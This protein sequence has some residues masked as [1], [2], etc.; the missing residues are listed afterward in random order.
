M[1][2]AIDTMTSTD[3]ASHVHNDDAN[4][5]STRERML[6][7]AEELFAAHGY[8]GT[9]LRAIMARAN[10]NTGSVHYHFRTKENLLEALF[11]MRVE[12]MNAE[13]RALLAACE[14]QDGKDIPDLHAVLRAFLGPAIRFARS[15]A[16]TNFNKVSALCSVDPNE[17][18]RRIAFAAYDEVAR[19]FTGLLR[20]ACPWLDDH[21]F[22]WRLNCMFGSMMYVRTNNGRVAQLLPG[23]PSDK[24]VDV[25]LEQLVAFAEGGLL[26]GR[27]SQGS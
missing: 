15:P 2:R 6:L 26:A 17:N 4:D 27:V 9:S 16:G 10:V 25:A 18:V 13:R 5:L 12:G 14:P 22:F 20:R 19:R 8:G 3:T 1:P 21:E 11:A 23:S 7:A 24:T